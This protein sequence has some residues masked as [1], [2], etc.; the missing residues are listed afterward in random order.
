MPYEGEFA[1]Y[2]AL[3][4]IA[5]TERVKNLVRNAR[6]QA[7]AVGPR[8]VPVLAPSPPSALPDFV[9][10]I[11]GS[12]AEID[13]R[14][15]FPGAKV[16]YCTV[17]SVLLDLHRMEELD[18]NRP[19]DPR[20]F[21]KTEEASSIDA[22]LPGSNVVTRTNTSAAESF[23]QALYESLHD[24]VVD[25]Q[26]GSPILETYEALLALK[27]DNRNGQRCPYDDEYACDGRLERLEK[28][29]TSCACDRR[30]AIYS[31]DA[32][33]IHEG[34]RSLGSN[35]EAYG[36]VMQVWERVLLVHLLRCFERRNWLDRVGRLAFM[37]DGPLA[38]FGHPAWLSAAITKELQRINVKVRQLT[39][40]D[41]LILGVEKTGEFVSHFDHIDQTEQPGEEYFPRRGY[42]LLTDKYIKE[43]VKFSDSD[44]RYG[45]DTYFG[46]KLFYKT[47]KGGRIVAT[48]PFL[49]AEQDTIQSDDISLYPQFSAVCA[50]LDKL[51]SSRFQNALTPLVAAN[52]QAAIP[53][54]LGAKVLQQ[55]ARALMKER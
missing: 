28:G 50:L 53:L 5:E 32:L 21:R 1:G 55:L 14:N 10:A 19:A 29:L 49:T 52:A 26:E 23:R 44:K 36:E 25:E 31:T 15:G 27:P 7:A 43:R 46:R 54:E 45:A 30:K 4:R 41:L 33:R 48:I 22:A 3:Q 37:L 35:L 40:N 8:V 2:R 12:L 17:A 20:E 34:F 13:V 16:G 39:G 6:V 24:G 9:F 38:V 11:D 18:E 47:S 51:V 42:Q